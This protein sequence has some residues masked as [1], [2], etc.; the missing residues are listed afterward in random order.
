MSVFHDLNLAS[1]YCKKLILLHGKKIFS[2]GKPEH[3][4]T[5][6]NLHRVY[7]IEASIKKHPLTDSLYLIPLI[8]NDHSSEGGLRIHIICGGGTGG[9]LIRT[10]LDRK[11]SIS[12]GVLNLLDSD[13]EIAQHLNV[14]TVEEAPFSPIT[15]EA[16]GENLKQ[17][18]GS[19]LVIITDF[20]VGYGNLKNLEAAEFALKNRIPTL[21]IDSKPIED[22]DFTKGLATKYY[23]ELIERGAIIVKSNKEA[24]DRVEAYTKR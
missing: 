23:S 11:F 17:I 3:V 7:G 21:I 8:R 15:K 14:K 4:L 9:Y 20:F 16:F 6:E 12:C 19:D 13:Y 1:R 5:E 24:L 22:R 10:L 2:I 18:Q